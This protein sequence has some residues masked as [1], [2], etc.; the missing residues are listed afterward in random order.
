[1]TALYLCVGW[2]SVVVC[3]LLV[4]H[5]ADEHDDDDET[6]PW[7]DRRPDWLD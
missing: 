7:V 4:A 3:L 6:A 2:F 1:M 5:W